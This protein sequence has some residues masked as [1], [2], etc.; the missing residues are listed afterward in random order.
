M[1]VRLPDGTI[2]KNIPDGMSKADLATKLKS[3][4]MNVPDSWMGAPAPTP[5]AT[6]AAASPD[7]SDGWAVSALKKL[8]GAGETGLHLATGFTGKIAGDLAGLDQ[9]AAG[10]IDPTADPAAAKQKVQDMFTYQPQT[11]AGKRYTANVD[12]LLQNTVG[13]A[14][15][16]VGDLAAQAT[17]A[18]G[19]DAN[20]Q[21]INRSGAT[22][23]A[24]QIPTLL[25]TLLPEAGAAA[26]AASDAKAIDAAPRQAQIQQA[27]DSGYKIPPNLVNKAGVGEKLMGVAGKDQINRG[28]SL[29]NQD[30]TNQL[31]KQE[32][33]IPP[34]QSLNAASLAEQAKGAESVYSQ[35]RKQGSFIPD[36]QLADDLSEVGKPLKGIMDPMSLNQTYRAIDSNQLVTDIR[37][38]R[39][40]AKVGFKSDD[41]A[42][43]R[44]AY[45]TQNQADAL[46]G[47][48]QRKLDD[49]SPGLADMFKAART[50]LAKIYSID[51]AM[52]ASG[53]IDA[54]KIARDRANGMPLTGNLAKIADAADSFG[55]VVRNTE[56]VSPPDSFSKL[57]FL[58]TMGSL[59]AGGGG[60]GGH[61]GAVSGA[62]AGTLLGAPAA[63]RAFLGSNKYQSTL[64]GRPPAPNPFMQLAAQPASPLAGLV[65]TA[66]ET[67]DQYQ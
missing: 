17:K 10:A 52:D 1:D 24:A 37:Q 43:V 46:E 3:N 47:F 53:R 25:G 40:D 38:L 39:A 58:T 66:P 21:D 13:K 60:V 31:A 26:K 45:K 5:Q 6:P 61:A 19:G 63:A 12:S 4:G 48:L 14:T 28:F 15:A 49:T 64:A 55:N 59:A 56:K 16:G 54:A 62:A 27:L 41:P 65:G 29:I 22:E 34:T 8:A 30:V 7:S 11:D 57:Q 9:V 20:L 32:A 50:K 2:V 67:S 18:V 35:V 51:N 44:T 42:T 36:K 33:G 23:I